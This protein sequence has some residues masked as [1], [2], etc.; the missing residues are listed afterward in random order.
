MKVAATLESFQI[1]SVEQVT[2]LSAKQLASLVEPSIRSLMSFQVLLLVLQDLL[3][4]TF[5]REQSS[6]RATGD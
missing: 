3:A 4:H 5:V 2:M 6:R 1:S